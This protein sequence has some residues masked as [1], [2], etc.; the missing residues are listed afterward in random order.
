[1]SSKK[2]SGAHACS[3]RRLHHA[4]EFCCRTRC[5]ASLG[6][7]GS[8]CGS[9]PG[10]SPLATDP[11]RSIERHGRAGRPTCGRPHGLAIAVLDSAGLSCCGAVSFGQGGKLKKKIPELRLALQGKLTEHHRFQLRLLMDQLDGLELLIAKVSARIETMAPF[12]LGAN[13]LD[14]LEPERLTRYLVK[15]LERLGHKV[16]LEP[17]HAA[18]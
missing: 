4:G 16:T 11:R 9:S 12:E 6:T 2:I 18:A 13:Y 3:P 5:G 17:N 14:Q 7:R 1:M 15:R 8:I 10:P